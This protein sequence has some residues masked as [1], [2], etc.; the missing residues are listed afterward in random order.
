MVFSKRFSQLFPATSLTI[1]S[2][3]FVRFSWGAAQLPAQPPSR[4]GKLGR[5]FSSAG[6]LRRETEKRVFFVF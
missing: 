3:L 5:D 2:S 6:R 4:F 1:C